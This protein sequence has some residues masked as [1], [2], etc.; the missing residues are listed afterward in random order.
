MGKAKEKDESDIESLTCL[1]KSLATKVVEL[2][3]GMNETSV[4]S[5]PSKY[6][7]NKNVALRNISSKL[8]KYSQSSNLVLNLDQ[9]MTNSYYAFHHEPH[10]KRTCPKWNLGMSSMDTHLS[11]KLMTN[12]HLKVKNKK[13]LHMMNLQVLGMY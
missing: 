7:P 5:R 1:I 2:K 6:P 4:S 8:T 12:E 10:S 11:N 9:L 13:L 3:K